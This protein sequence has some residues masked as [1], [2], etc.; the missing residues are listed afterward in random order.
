VTK[1]VC[2]SNIISLIIPFQELA[3]QACSGETEKNVY[4]PNSVAW[5]GRDLPLCPCKSGVD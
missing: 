3:V 1:S 2:W 5:Q 4:M